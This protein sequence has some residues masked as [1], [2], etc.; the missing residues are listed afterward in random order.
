MGSGRKAVDLPRPLGME[1]DRKEAVADRWSTKLEIRL[2][3]GS[4]ELEGE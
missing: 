1:V 2:G 3:D 4:G